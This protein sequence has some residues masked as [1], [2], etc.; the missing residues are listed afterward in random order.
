[1]AHRNFIRMLACVLLSAVFAHASL[2]QVPEATAPAITVANPV[3]AVP[4][5]GGAAATSTS[6]SQETKPSVRSCSEADIRGKWKL[7]RVFETPAGERTNDFKAFPNQI[8]E[9]A[10]QNILYETKSK[11]Q[12]NKAAGNAAKANKAN[13]EGKKSGKK[14]G[15]KNANKEALQYILD[16]DGVLFIYRNQAFSHSYYCG[17][18]EN[19]AGVYHKG[20]MLLTPTSTDKKELFELYRKAGRRK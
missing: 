19:D 5:G 4:F 20:D 6:A 17:I 14:A 1:M 15:R 9:F 10:S 18:A 13:K 16:K 11:G 3:P 8:T 12:K 7:H 2:A